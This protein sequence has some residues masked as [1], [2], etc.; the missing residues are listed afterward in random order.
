MYYHSDNANRAAHK[1][2]SGAA[3]L[4]SILPVVFF[5]WATIDLIVRPGWPK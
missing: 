1:K 5:A 3:D 4:T 2:M